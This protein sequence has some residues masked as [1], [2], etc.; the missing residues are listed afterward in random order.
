MLL[1]EYQER[2]AATDGGTPA[3]DGA[4]RILPGLYNVLGL[5]G[6]AGEVGEKIK[7]YARDGGDFIQTRAAVQKE[8]GDVLWYL[9]AVARNWMLTLEEVA[10]GNLDKLAARKAAGTLSGSGDSR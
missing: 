5:N 3:H 6:E 9:A 1:N 10:Q 4:G 2:A 7:K 8:L